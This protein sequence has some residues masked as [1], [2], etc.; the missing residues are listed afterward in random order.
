MTRPRAQGV[1]FPTKAPQPKLTRAQI[2]AAQKQ[3]A[4]SLRVTR[5]I[6]DRLSA[7]EREDERIAIEQ[8][9]ARANA[10]LAQR[11]DPE[12]LN[13]LCQRAEGKTT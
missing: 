11:I 9:V 1:R 4:E 8:A 2:K 10:A 3:R 7:K 12:E 5:E 6:V 13:A